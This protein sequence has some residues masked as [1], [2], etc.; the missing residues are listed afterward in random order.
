MRN[1]Y[2]IF[3]MAACLA[4][5][6]LPDAMAADEPAGNPAPTD[7]PSTLDAPNPDEMPPSPPPPG[8]DTGSAPDYPNPD[9][10]PVTG[11]SGSTT[12]VPPAEE[13]EGQFWGKYIGG[14]FGINNS[15]A[16]GSIS[17][18]SAT[19]FIYGMQGGYLQGGY[20]WDLDTFI[21]GIGGY[22]DWNNFSQHSNGVS[23]ATRS[24]GLD[25]KIGYLIGNWLPYVKRGYGFSTGTGNPDLNHVSNKGFNNAIGVE[26]NFTP[27]WSAI[28][29]YKINRFSNKSDTITIVDKT[30]SFGVNYYFDIPL[31][32][33]IKKKKQLE[34]IVIPPPELPP[35]A[36]PEAP[37]AP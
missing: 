31:K 10:E 32:K 1:I 12:I 19:T 13:E 34:N 7:A 11:E 23:Y 26:Y 21:A 35:E 37:P 24:W 25:A 2:F 20:N 3:S 36:L 17:A 22:A 27:R 16:S 18:P 33:Q 4:F 30:F 28:F 5:A 15:S 9:A 6:Y 8:E 29:E 14:K